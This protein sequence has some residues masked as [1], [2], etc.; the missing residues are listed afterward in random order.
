MKACCALRKALDLLDYDD[1]SIEHMMRLLLRA[2]MEAS[3]LRR[4]EGRRFLGSL[5]AVH[6]Q[7]AREV[8]AVMRNQVTGTRRPLART[9]G[10][11]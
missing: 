9:P 10:R 4:T 7:V 6:P 1:P 2:A 3:F 11:S 5:L 8:A